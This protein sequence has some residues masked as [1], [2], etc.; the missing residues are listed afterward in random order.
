MGRGRCQANGITLQA[1]NS[2]IR[3]LRIQGFVNGTTR[4]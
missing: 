2:T 4:A 1:S 3:G